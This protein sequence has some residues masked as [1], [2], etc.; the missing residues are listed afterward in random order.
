MDKKTLIIYSIVGGLLITL[1][2]GLVPS[3]QDVVGVDY[4]GSPWP[5]MSKSSGTSETIWA[6]LILDSVCW[7]VVVFSSYYLFERT[8]NGKKKRKR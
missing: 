6:N 7:G 1:V 2:S 3:I 4:W 8:T 5:W